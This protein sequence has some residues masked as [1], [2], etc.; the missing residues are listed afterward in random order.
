MIDR[1]PGMAVSSV[2]AA[3]VIGAVNFTCD[4]HLLTSMRGGCHNVVVSA[5]CWAV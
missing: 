3:E 1:M 5:I 2:G 4:H